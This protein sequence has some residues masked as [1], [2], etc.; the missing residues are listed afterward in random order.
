MK[1][2]K[3]CAIVGALLLLSSFLLVPQ[4]HAALSLAQEKNQEKNNECG[5]EATDRERS[6]CLAQEN[7]DKF[8][9]VSSGSVSFENR[10]TAGD[11]VI[12][13]IY[14]GPSS[15]IVSVTDSQ[16][17]VY[18]QIGTALSSPT[19]NQSAALFY[20]KAI[21]GGPDTVTVRLNAVPGSPGL[22]IY[23]FEY[24]GLDTISPLDGNAQAAG[25]SSSVSSGSLTTTVSGD[26]LFGFCV[27][28]ASCSEGEGFT[29][30]S[31]F[32]GNLGE[33]KILNAAGTTSATATA[34]QPWTMQAAAFKPAQT[35]AA[36]ATDNEFGS[37][38][39][40][41]ISFENA[42]TAGDLLIVG[43]Y[44]GPSSSIVS[45]TDSQANVYTQIGTA[46]SS[47]TNKQSGALFYAKNIKGGPDTVT[48]RLDAVPESPGL[49]IYIFEYKGIDTFSPLDG[50]AQA[51]GTSHTVSSGN[52]TTT[53]PGDLLF[54][55]CVSDNKCR[56]GEGFTAR[57]TGEGNL[58]EDKIL[59]AAG[60]TSATARANEPWTMQAA[61][62]K[63][64]DT[65][66]PSV[67]M[68]LKATPVSTSQIN[69]S[70][71]ASTDPDSPVAGYNIYRNNTKVA[72]ATGT[73]FS[74]TGLSGNTTYSYT[75][76]AF[77]PAGNVSLQSSA[78][79]ATTFGALPTA[80]QHVGSKVTGP[81]RPFE[82]FSGDTYQE[83]D[84]RFDAPVLSGNCIIVGVSWSASG[85][86]PTVT[87]DKN[88]TYT[89]GPQN[90]DGNRA[91]GIWYLLNVT[92][93]PRVIQARFSSQNRLIS[94]IA[95]EFY[96]IATSSPPDG[97]SDGTGAS[98]ASVATRAITTTADNDLIWQFGLQDSGAAMT[99]WT[100]GSNWKLICPDMQETGQAA[101][102]TI[103]TVHGSITPTLTQSPA[104]NPWLTVAIAFKSAAA[105]TAPSTTQ[106]RIVQHTHTA[107]DTTGM[108]GFSTVETSVTGNLLVLT[109]IGYTGVVIS[110]I[111]DTAGNTWK[112]VNPGSL[113]NGGLSGAVQ[114]WYAANVAPAAALTI[115]IDFQGT[116]Y[117]SGSTIHVMDIV[118][119]ASSPLDTIATAG[120]P[121]PTTSTVGASITPGTP[122]GLV[123]FNFTVYSNTVLASS[124]S[125]FFMST[126]NPEKESSFVDNNNGGAVSY[127]TDS[128]TIQNTWTSDAPLDSFGEID[129][130]FIEKPSNVQPPATPT[131]L[132]ALGSVGGTTLNWTAATEKAGVALY[133][134]YR[135]TTPGFAPTRGTRI[136]QA[137]STAYTDFAP[138]G[139]Y[140]YV[141]TAE[142]RNG[143]I[144][145]PSSEA[146]ARVA[147]D[148]IPPSAP[149]NLIATPISSSRINLSWTASTDDVAVAG[150]RVFR[151]GSLIATSRSTSYVDTG[152]SPSTTY[153]Y[154]VTA[155]DP[156]G[157]V[158]PASPGAN[159]TT[160]PPAR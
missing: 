103:Q 95:S 154:T 87:D 33:D 29:A 144:S 90:S 38:K 125:T 160:F 22:G 10:T 134:I 92:N 4:A 151:N 45:V 143:N 158:S 44:F 147:A 7:E 14:F 49:G 15:S 96:N 61:A 12:V 27:S 52:L 46:L 48:V 97:T 89:P 50:N 142:D 76:S 81:Y 84:I 71:T 146:G 137:T 24:K 35:V 110:A 74:D 150:Y 153:T 39:S 11:L 136:G 80:V 75:L 73:S 111:T 118:N 56:K 128:S 65:T 138:A 72:T 99:T 83:Y 5:D 85:V 9:S 109:W 51:T 139:T 124:Q 70:W 53:V 93:G 112:D 117:Y 36:Q 149:L 78:V 116:I 59:N 16:A 63:P 101:Q 18:S 115:R 132:T 121:A 155:I 34:D 6:V 77:D 104:T 3:N 130:S 1:R 57:S 60:T 140:Y 43:I 100:P 108:Q 19:N 113:P 55:F 68:G 13:G 20:A 31:T 127:H 156:S 67:P 8:E 30:R 41:S 102:Y 94:L 133:N 32:D 126:T 58:G 119:A 64:V 26:L 159:A 91:I 17:N 88:N 82:P 122:R 148:N 66:P 152:L 23:I 79:S 37:V 105:G 129:A 98:G 54:G 21:K 28:D 40:A 107:F 2:V 123:I 86:T 42:T 135:S 141:V 25:S 131:S 120:G 145:V 69:L 157:N 62:F 47:P 114:T 106:M